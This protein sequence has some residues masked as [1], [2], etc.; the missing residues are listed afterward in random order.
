MS[1]LLNDP[2]DPRRHHP[3]PPPYPAMPTPPASTASYP[4]DHSPLP[5]VGQTRCCKSLPAP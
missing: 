1:Y 4:A 2:Y 3:S 5:K